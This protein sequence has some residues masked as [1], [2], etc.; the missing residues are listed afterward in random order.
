MIVTTDSFKYYAPVIKR[1]FAGSP[2]AYIQVDNTYR[3]R[4]IVVSTA[5]MVMGTPKLYELAAARSEDSKRPNTSYVERVN[6]HKRMSCSMLRRRTP[7][8]A[9]SPER[10]EEALEL[11]RVI[12]NFV[13]VHSSLRFGKVKRTPTTQARIFSRALTLREIFSW[14]APQDSRQRR[15]VGRLLAEC[16]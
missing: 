4:G 15:R 10:L 14:R 16:P 8:P 3:R 11:V 1:V 6:L 12:Y 7:S 2:V 13:R 5:T 9:R